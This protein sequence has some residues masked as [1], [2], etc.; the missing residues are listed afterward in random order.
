MSSPDVNKLIG[1]EIVRRRI[2]IG[3][4]QGELAENA[5]FKQQFT[6][7]IERGNQNL[8]LTEAIAFATA[9]GCSVDDIAKPAA[10]LVS[11]RIRAISEAR[12]AQQIADLKAR[13][14]VL[15]GGEQR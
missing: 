4:T 5:G 2:A 12:K 13:L 10:D 15:E 3:L 6:C 11:A 8:K 9:L 1:S 7:K 14:A